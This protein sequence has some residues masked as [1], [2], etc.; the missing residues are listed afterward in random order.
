MH[1]LVVTRKIKFRENSPNSQ[2]FQGPTQSDRS[3][4]GQR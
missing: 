2:K 3:Q 4:A 1:L